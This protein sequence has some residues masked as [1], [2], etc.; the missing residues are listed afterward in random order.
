MTWDYTTSWAIYMRA[1]A[2][3]NS[4]ARASEAIISQ[5]CNNA[6]GYIN[7]ATRYDWTAASAAI[8]SNYPHIKPV[9]AGAITDLA[10]IDMIWYDPSGY[11]SRGEAEDITNILHDRATKAIDFLKSMKKPEVVIT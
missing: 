3:V 2:N 11:T 8:N 1:G 5:F 7:A 10:A 4:T 6:Q 9:L